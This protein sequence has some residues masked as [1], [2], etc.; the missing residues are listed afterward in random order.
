M[1]GCPVAANGQES[2]NA[3]AGCPVPDRPAGTGRAGAGT[4]A[5]F[6]STQ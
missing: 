1:T 6:N 5:G 3:V 4:A 2:G